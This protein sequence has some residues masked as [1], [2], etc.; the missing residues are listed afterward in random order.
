M[1]VDTLNDLKSGNRTSSHY[2]ET[3]RPLKELHFL[4]VAGKSDSD[5]ADA[6]RDSMDDHW[7]HLS[8]IETRRVR[9]LSADLYTLVDPPTPP[10]QLDQE[11][12]ETCRLAEAAWRNNDWD[13]TLEL[14]RNRPHP[15][16]PAHVA[17]MR[18]AC[19]EKLGDLETSR[20]FLERAASLS[21]GNAQYLLAFT[22]N[23]LRLGRLT[24]VI[25]VADRISALDKRG[26]PDVLFGVASVLVGSI[27]LV[28]DAEAKKR[29]IAK[30]IDVIRIAIANEEQ[31][32][33]KERSQSSI[34]TSYVNLGTCYRLLGRDD[35]ALGAYNAALDLDRDNDA[36]LVGRGLLQFRCDR[37]ASIEDFRRAVQGKSAF[38][39]P[40]YFYAF[41]LASRG[42]FDECI[43]VCRSG[44]QRTND[45]SMQ[46][47][48]YQWIAIAQDA[49]GESKDS[50]QENF[51]IARSLAPLNQGIFKNYQLF[52][53]SLGNPAAARPDWNLEGDRNEDEASQ[54]VIDRFINRVHSSTL[55]A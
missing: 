16:P 17:F 33:E 10:R 18:A 24:D 53:H 20:L 13:G 52:L 26:P 9:G 14:L 40:Y 25:S 55:V 22:W 43:R 51:E 45:A 31:L 1:A 46:A 54:D 7:Y 2:R 34:V 38:V 49:L 4:M 8:P 47:E 32:P 21:P 27:Q 5:E 23:L 42:Q 39:W 37:P 19:W 41:H 15:Y 35:L 12:A 11:T 30:A 50:V 6:V 48:F 3:V 29:V 28:G 36:A 44:L